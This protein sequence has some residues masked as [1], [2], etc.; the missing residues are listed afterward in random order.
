VTKPSVGDATIPPAGI[1]PQQAD[2]RNSRSNRK[3]AD[4]ASTPAPGFN[5]D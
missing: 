3:S 2:D 4:A 1:S 5:L